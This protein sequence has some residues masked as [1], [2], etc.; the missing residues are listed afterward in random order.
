MSWITKLPPAALGLSLCGGEHKLHWTLK[1]IHRDS[2]QQARM[3]ELSKAVALKCKQE[4]LNIPGMALTKAPSRHTIA[5]LAAR[6]CR[7]AGSSGRCT[8][9]WRTASHKEH[10][11]AVAEP[12]NKSQRHTCARLHVAALHCVYLRHILQKVFPRRLRKTSECPDGGICFRAA[13][14]AVCKKPR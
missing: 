13:R 3:K 4:S 9:T 8:D 10:V 2:G 12:R 7:E 11:A 14:K 6:L 1:D 5:G